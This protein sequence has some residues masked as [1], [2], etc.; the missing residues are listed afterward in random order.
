MRR[1]VSSRGAWSPP[2]RMPRPPIVRPGDS[3]RCSGGA[4]SSASSQS[5]RPCGAGPWLVSIQLSSNFEP[6][7]RRPAQQRERLGQVQAHAVAAACGLQPDGEA[8]DRD[9]RLGRGQGPGE[10]QRT[11]QQLR[12]V[13]EPGRRGCPVGRQ[14]RALEQGADRRLAGVVAEVPVEQRGHVG[15]RDQHGRS[16]VENGLQRRQGDRRGVRRVGAAAAG[17]QRERRCGSEQA[18]RDESRFAAEAQAELDPPAA[19]GGGAGVHAE[20]RCHRDAA[21]DQA[22][23]PEHR[24][25][26]QGPG[27]VRPQ[28]GGD[29]ADHRNAGPAEDDVEDQRGLQAGGHAGHGD[30]ETG[31]V[32][33]DPHPAGQPGEQRREGGRELAEAGCGSRRPGPAERAERVRS[34]SRQR[35]RVEL[36]ARAYRERVAQRGDD[37]GDGGGQASAGHPGQLVEHERQRLGHGGGGRQARPVPAGSNGISAPAAGRR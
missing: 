8:A 23:R 10:G 16:G 30:S 6:D 25:D 29:V 4:G 9:R 18:A 34:P 33:S 26:L 5:V 36:S 19:A 17:G 31:A 15:Q 14:H 28:V 37:A 35:V 7:A 13:G 12:R 24:G 21:H 3:A 2:M 27:G 32:V 20:E 1:P 22:E 11:R